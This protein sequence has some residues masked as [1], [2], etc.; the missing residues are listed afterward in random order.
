MDVLRIAWKVFVWL[1]IIMF[2]M[3]ALNA[4]ALFIQF[5]WLE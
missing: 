1:N 3:F 5:Y 2:T 4:I